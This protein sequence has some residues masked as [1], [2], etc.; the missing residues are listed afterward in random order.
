MQW[1]SQEHDWE[2]VKPAWWTPGPVTLRWYPDPLRSP[3][4]LAEPE[5][6]PDT[7]TTKKLIEPPD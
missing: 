3:L 6:E 7:Q 2:D 1:P 4:C 5:S